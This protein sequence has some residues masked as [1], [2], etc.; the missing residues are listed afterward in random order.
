MAILETVKKRF[1]TIVLGLVVFMLSIVFVLEF[2]GPQSRGCT[3]SLDAKGYAAKVHGRTITEGDFRAVYTLSGFN[4][5]PLESAR[6]S[7]VRELTLEGLI[8]RDL[9]AQW[10]RDLGFSVTEDEVMQRL[11]QE[12]TMRVSASVKAPA[13]FLSGE[14]PV[15]VKNKNEEFDK[16]NARRFIQYY[17]QRSIQEFSQSQVQEELAHLAQE[18]LKATTRVGPE[19]VWQTYLFKNDRA[20]LNYVRFSPSYYQESLVPTEAEVTLWAKAHKAQIDKAFTDQKHRFTGLEKQVRARHILI[21]VEETA[22]EEEKQKAKKTAEGI[23]AKAKAA[24]ADFAALAR[25]YSQDVGS[26]KKGGDLGYNPKGRMVAPFDDVQFKLAPGQISELV[27]TQ[28]GFHIIKVEGSRQG[29]IPEAEAKAELALELYR[30]GRASELAKTAAWALYKEVKR[31]TEMAQALALMLGKPVAEAKNKAASKEDSEKEDKTDDA[32]MPKVQETSAF[33]RSDVPIAGPF[34]AKPIVQTAFQ[35]KM[36]KPLPDAPLQLGQE[37]VVVQLTERK[38]PQKAD[39]TPE[40]AKTLEKNLLAA[41]NKELLEHTIL[42][43][44]TKG[45]AESTIEINPQILQYTQPTE[46]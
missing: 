34:D 31:G 28:Y 42:A 15:P 20:K 38:T 29:N 5:Y 35:L 21:K 18:L 1:E 33:N 3:S 37:W 26:A 30:E 44:R 41:K 22:S 2:G 9:W 19:E 23:L 6:S 43:M 14:V 45:T 10:A 32:L 40:E 25:T 12:G 36:E 16:E 8:E 4:R 46:P 27:Q 17:L 7:H 13:S 11:A 39:L 24:N